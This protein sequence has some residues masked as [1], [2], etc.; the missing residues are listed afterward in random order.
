MVFRPPT[1]CCNKIGDG[2]NTVSESTAQ[3]RTQW[4]SLSSPS[5]GG[6]I[7]EFLSASYL[8][9]EANSPSFSQN[10][11]SKHGKCGKCGQR[12]AKMR[13]TGFIVTGFSFLGDPQHRSLEALHGKKSRTSLKKV[14]PGLL[15]PRL[16]VL[17]G[18][19]RP[20]PPRFQPYSENGPFY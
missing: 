9:A 2:L 1:I 12:N 15:A 8:C 10:S 4:V 17:K 11:Q 19:R 16:S 5:S 3:H 20:T 6:E 18:G 7:S 13:L 14:L